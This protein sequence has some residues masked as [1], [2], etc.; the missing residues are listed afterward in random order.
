MTYYTVLISGSNIFF[1]QYENSDPIVGFISQRLIEAESED[2]A[3][4]IAKRDILVNW[5]HSFNA[6]RR[7]GLP[8][9]Q[10]EYIA[11]FQGWIK[12]KTKHDYYWYSDEAQKE[13]LLSKVK[14]TDNKWWRW[15]T[16]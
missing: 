2:L 1:E 3:T 15:H 16:Y 5:N 10:L 7:L 12:P 6:D 4:A 11:A 8:S 13:E 9:L 14:K